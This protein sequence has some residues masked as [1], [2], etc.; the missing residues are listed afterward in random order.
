MQAV[1]AMY[2]RSPCAGAELASLP[3][4]I[5]VK[6][7]GYEVGGQMIAAGPPCMEQTFGACQTV[8]VQS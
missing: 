7:T 5:T 8:K 3:K 1:A 6:V 4:N 2:L